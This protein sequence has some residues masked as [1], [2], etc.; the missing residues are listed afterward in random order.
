MDVKVRLASAYP[1][2]SVHE[3]R[4]VGVVV[5]I[6]ICYIE[7]SIFD[8][9]VISE[10]EPISEDQKWSQLK[11]IPSVASHSMVV[12][13][14]GR[15]KELFIFVL[16]HHSFL[17]LFSLFFGTRGASSWPI[18][19][20]FGVPKNFSY[21]QANFP[22]RS[23]LFLKILL[24]PSSELSWSSAFLLLRLQSSGCLIV[25]TFSC[26]SITC[27]D[28]SHSSSNHPSSLLI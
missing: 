5:I 4:L 26:L 14:F 2:A 8:K 10:D 17:L 28:F 27:P 19:A 22:F 18:I 21:K 7:S 15:A 13:F 16:H 6:C 12:P 3:E 9:Q 20:S 1:S 11:S 23:H 24:K 25:R